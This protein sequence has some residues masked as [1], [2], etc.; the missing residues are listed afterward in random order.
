MR[1]EATTTTIRLPRVVVRPSRFRPNVVVEGFVDVDTGGPALAPYEEEGVA[2]RSLEL[3]SH[4]PDDST[5]AGSNPRRGHP[6]AAVRRCER[7]SMV[8]IEQANGERTP[9]PMLSLAAF[10]NQS[11]KNAAADADANGTEGAR[12]G[13]GGFTFGVLFNVDDGGDGT[14]FFER[15]GRR[16]RRRMRRRVSRLLAPAVKKPVT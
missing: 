10:R 6:L 15:R 4:L 11:R 14:G 5:A 12:G 1:N 2:W 7:C 8:G 16:A 13:G 3:V 9:E